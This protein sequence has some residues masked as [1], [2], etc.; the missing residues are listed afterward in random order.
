MATVTP[1]CSEQQAMRLTLFSYPFLFFFLRVFGFDIPGGE[2]KIF[3]N[4]RRILLLLC[5]ESAQNQQHMAIDFVCG[6]DGLGM[7]KKRLACSWL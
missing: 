5:V 4:D 7:Q 2:S 6:K 1:E 3:Y